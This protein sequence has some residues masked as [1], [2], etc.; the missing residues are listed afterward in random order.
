MILLDQEIYINQLLTSHK[1]MAILDKNPEIKKIICPP[2]VYKRTA[3]K[4]IEALA[5][6]GVK[7]EPVSKRGRPKKYDEKDLEKINKLSNQGSTPREISDTLEI[8]LKTVY[9]FIGSPLKRGRKPKYSLKTA[10][11]VK[12]MHDEGHSVKEISENLDIPI[13]SIYSLLNKNKQ[14]NIKK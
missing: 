13:R 1:I 3:P 4:Y 11:K 14:P 6:L 12:S 10:Q 7:V 9:Y 5:N 8:P 2:S